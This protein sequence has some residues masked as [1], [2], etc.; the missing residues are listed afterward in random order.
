MTPTR[1]PA[2]ANAPLLDVTI[3][4]HPQ[5]GI[6]Q[7]AAMPMYVR[8][9]Q[10]VQ[11]NELPAHIANKLAEHAE[12]R[13]IDLKN[14]RAW[15]THSQNPSASSG[16]GKLLRRRANP[17]DPDDE[18]YTIVVLH[19]TQVLVA[20]DGAKRGTA[21]LSLPLAQASLADGLGLT[22]TLKSEA[23]DQAG[24]TLTG[25]PG[26]HTGSFYIGL[27]PE[28]AAAECIS[29]VRSAITAAKNPVV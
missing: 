28:P 2:T 15:L 11:L 14:V 22:G 24:F 20:I 27:G 25:I 10:A 1:N 3:V 13:Q 16:F 26:E 19:P 5:R 6:R 12:P 9:T 8:N 18:H 29:A 17:S 7:D 4:E 23:I 21:V